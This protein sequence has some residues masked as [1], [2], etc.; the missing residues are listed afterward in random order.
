MGIFEWG[1]K[2][3]PWLFHFNASSCNNCDIEIVAALTPKFDVERFGALLVGTPRHA[4]I[5]VVTGF[6]NKKTA[7]RLKR[8][9]EQMPS[10]KVV[11]AVGT[12]ACTGGIF[13]GSHVMA[14]PVDKIIPV[15]AYVPGCPPRPQAIILGLAQAFEILARKRKE[16]KQKKKG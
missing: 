1:L 16:L 7:P 11:V 2:K 8:I 9:Y 13:D 3:S 12:C 4:D 14:G 15:D 5:L 6:V 10:P